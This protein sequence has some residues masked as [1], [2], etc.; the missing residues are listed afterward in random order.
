MIEQA[1]DTSRL[2]R[3]TRARYM[4]TLINSSIRLRSALED[5][6]Q[7]KWH[8]RWFTLVTGPAHHH[9][10]GAFKCFVDELDDI[11][12]MLAA[13]TRDVL[14]NFNV[15]RVTPQPTLCTEQH[16]STCPGTGSP[17]LDIVSCVSTLRTR[18]GR[19]NP[20]ESNRAHLHH[21]VT[22]LIFVVGPSGS[23]LAACAQVARQH[24]IFNVQLLQTKNHPDVFGV[25]HNASFF[26]SMN[27]APFGGN[28]S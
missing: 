4:G 23:A 7:P 8:R 24:S 3:V 10:R 28:N 2:T 15:H 16:E 21:L 25:I 11:L 12:L 13:V 5:G 18:I 19:S 20:K 27:L 22:S 9:R 14:F 1:R 6:L 17:P 26:R